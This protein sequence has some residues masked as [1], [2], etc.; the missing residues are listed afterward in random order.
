MKMWNFKKP[1]FHL[2]LIFVASA[3]LIF[4]LMGLAYK[5]LEKLS[6]NTSYVNRSYEVSL[7]LERIYTHVKDVEILQRQ[8]I[9]T[10][11]A[12]IKAD[13]D[14]TI[15]DIEAG[16][17]KLQVETTGNPEQKQNGEVLYGY[18][19]EH[20]MIVDKALHTDF[21]KDDPDELKHNLLAGKNVMANV[22][23][24][25]TEMLAIENGLLKKRKNEFHITQQSTP[26]FL[27]LISLLA[28]GLLA[29]AFHRIFTDFREQESVNS[30]L[31]IVLNASNLAEIVGGFGVWILNLESKTY[32][33]S[34]NQY[35]LLGYQPQEFRASLDFFLKHVHPED[36]DDIKEK[37]QLLTE[38]SDPSPSVFR[39][40]KKDGSLRYFQTTGA[41]VKLKSGEKVFLG[42][43]ADITHEIDSTLMLEE[44]NR[45]L[46]ANNQELV[47]FNYVASHDLQE[48]LRK[49]ETFITRLK[50]KD[51]TNL[52]ESGKMFLEKMH[53]SAGRMRTLI[54]DLL[55]FSR[56]TRAEKVFE[57]TDLDSV[58]HHAQEELQQMI[59]EK[60]AVISFVK[61][62]V[63]EVIPFQIQQL[64]INILSNSLKYCKA[65][66]PAFIGIKYE[67]VNSRDEA[68]LPKNNL[69]YHKFIFSDNGIGFEQQYADKIFDVFNRLHSREDYAGTGIG[70]A[71]CK[72]IVENH[73]GYIFASSKPL[74]GAVFT[75]YLPDKH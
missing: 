32:Q 68:W 7:T 61:L 15:A 57:S 73:K 9:L 74:C 29:F 47:A 14:L 63:L 35:R 62:P 36:Q 39:V 24:Q 12:G 50:E 6:H 16:F 65:D 41:I 66:V 26:L 3:A 75:V 58:M 70:L 64:F 59:E 56:T 38:Q 23:A 28:L 8:Y 30:R 72:K 54:D 37:V 25:I 53:S 48:P 60:K 1:S 18:I 4:F 13:I 5:Q 20:Y 43:T 67:V 49:I 2:I 11:D 46:E 44:Q 17:K 69:T 34:D 22:R 40:Y 10:R 19:Q 21:G 27:Y 31:Q 51:G 42:I 55:L 45:T 52:T 33:F 71:V